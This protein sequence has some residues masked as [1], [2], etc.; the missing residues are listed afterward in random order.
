[1]GSWKKEQQSLLP[2]AEPTEKDVYFFAGFYEGE[3]SACLTKSN[4]TIVQVPQKDPEV[5]Y[6][7]RSLWGGS[8][9]PNGKGIHVWV[10]TGDRARIFL[11]AIYPFLSGRRKQQIEKA[12]GLTLTGK[13]QSLLV[14]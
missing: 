14:E 11:I 3:G 6:T 2:T 10:V 5:L 13:T 7:A 8:I 12:G 9:R 4:G 1:M